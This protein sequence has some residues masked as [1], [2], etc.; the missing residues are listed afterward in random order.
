MIF[1]RRLAKRVLIWLRW[2]CAVAA[3]CM[4]AA[5]FASIWW[6]SGISGPRFGAFF[7]LGYFTLTIHFDVMVGGEWRTLLE[8]V[9]KGSSVAWRN[10]WDCHA[11][12]YY[13]GATPSVAG[14]SLLIPAWSMAMPAALVSAWGFALARRSAKQSGACLHCGHTLAG[15][16]ICPECGTPASAARS[17]TG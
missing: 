11:G 13:F 12:F 8:P 7:H 9:P 6:T 14:W 1:M 16:V 2:P 10:W 17:A 15:A 5:A 4:L 3:A